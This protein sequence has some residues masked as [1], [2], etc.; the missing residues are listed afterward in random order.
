MG[1]PISE[2][3]DVERCLEAFNCVPVWCNVKEFGKAY[4]G[5]CK[6]VL[7]PV[8]HNVSSVYNSGSG[9]DADVG[10]VSAPLD[11]A[12]SSPNSPNSNKTNKT[13]STNNTSTNNTST[14][15]TS[16]NNTSTG[17]SNNSKNNLSGGGSSFASSLGSNSSGYISERNNNTVEAFEGA[18]TSLNV[19]GDGGK[20]AVLWAAFMAVNKQF[21]DTIIQHFNEGDLV[22]IHGFHLLLLPSFLTRRV[23]PMAKIG[24]FLH[25]PFPSSE[26]F[27]TLWCREDLLRGMLNADQVGFHLYEYARHFLTCCRRLLGMTYG[28][29]PDTYGGH[30]LA[31]DANG[32][33]V[34]ITSIHAGV[35]TPVLN[36]MLEQPETLDKVNVLRDQHK[37]KI[38]M[39]A[40]DR[41]ESLKGAPLKL[42]GLERFLE[43]R[44]EYIGRV[45]LIQVGISAFERGDDYLSTRAE[46]I[47]LTKKINS[48]WP[49]TIQYRECQES[50][51]RLAQRMSLL[52]A[53]DI[54]VVT[55]LRDG[56]ARLPLEFAVAHQ[57]ALSYDVGTGTG[58]GNGNGNGN[59]DKVG[60]D[61][62]RPGVIILSE[63]S[64]CCR[65][66]RGAINVNPWKISEIAFAIERALC[67]KK[68][69]H[70]QRVKF[71]LEFVSRVTTQRWALAVLLDLK[72]VKKND[73]QLQYT[74]AGLGL[75]FRLLE[76]DK[77][78]T[79]LD[80]SKVT[81]AYRNSYRRLIMLDYGGTLLDD[82]DDKVDS[83]R[84]FNVSMNAS[85][86]EAP[87][88]ELVESLTILCSDPR[89]CVFVVSGKERSALMETL[90]G[91]PN[92]GLAAE[93]G[94]YYKFGLKSKWDTM[95]GHGHGHGS[96]KEAALSV[97]DVYCERTHG[98][99][100]EQTESKLI[101][102]YKD[103]DPEYGYLQ[104]KELEDH[105][106]HALKQ[107]SVDV[108]HGGGSQ[109]GYLEVRP[110][111]V[112]KGI[113]LMEILKGLSDN[114][115]DDNKL[116]DNKLNDNKLNDNKLNDNKLNEVGA[117]K[118]DF[119]L[120]VGDDHCDE[121]MFSAAR[122]IGRRQRDIR[123]RSKAAASVITP[124]SIFGQSSLMGD[125]ATA[126]CDSHVSTEMEFFTCTVGKKPSA[127][128]N[129]LN[130]VSEV[131]EL[132]GTFNKISSRNKGN[133]ST[134]DLDTLSDYNFSGGNGG[135]NLDESGNLQGL[136]PSEMEEISRNFKVQAQILGAAMN[137]AETISA[138]LTRGAV[139]S[140][141]VRS[142]SLGVLATSF[143]QQGHS[144]AGGGM[145]GGGGGGLGLGG[146]GGGGSGNRTLKMEKQVSM[147]LQGF[148]ENIN[149]DKSEDE[150]SDGDGVFF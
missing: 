9:V 44:P 61:E 74:G 123:L 139:G 63:F 30:N 37:G 58:N 95:V 29:V 51:M 134:T 15:N 75:G 143:K 18:Q 122:N 57:D 47:R 69:E 32:R 97:M 43:K 138:G 13:S 130:D 4:N 31:V 118:V 149:D 8:F 52:R 110:Q 85:S 1:V 135:G 68:E 83:V 140:H 150:D 14:N 34:T 121:P 60:D 5:F 10:L 64:S 55:S 49:G 99:Y 62:Y 76:M 128:A 7:W 21:A 54:A 98:S 41:L 33:K 3:N 131:V 146:G 39:V 96:W 53:A 66:M 100:V 137:N 77:G 145:G 17:T 93:H 109:N 101:W 108:L 48:A 111:G 94:M 36:K 142:T 105:L 102:H 6:G 114:K 86:R 88:E 124:K 82:D 45:V 28:M 2:R 84:K 72:G 35:D 26:I 127:A 73:Q 42:L 92:L 24:I 27:R 148:L 11:A 133:Y 117:K 144:A 129:F 16:T 65:V 115:L 80:T 147:S 141:I 20:Q 107:F 12:S 40:I 56:L 125:D 89:N 103:T 104:S 90:G 38:V 78:F 126:A 106:Q 19:H 136:T 22:W 67:M 112:N 113:L 91:I 70:A 79:G 23:G 25:T 46:V 119:L 71:N 81:R 132:L 59:G 116:N 87:T 120:C 50:E